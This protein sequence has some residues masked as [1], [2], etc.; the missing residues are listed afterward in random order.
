MKKKA[1]TP[2]SIAID[3][4]EANVLSR[5]GSNV[6]AY[7]VLTAVE[8]IIR[9]QTELKVTVLLA[10]PAVSDMP[11]ASKNWQYRVLG[12]KFLW[13]Q[14]ALPLHLFIHKNKYHVFFTPGH[15]APRICLIPYVSSVMDLAFLQYPE[16]FLPKDVY[17]LR[18]WTSY[19]VLGA[20]KIIAISNHT[21]SQVIKTYDKK[22][23]D[24]VVAY[25]A[26][27]KPAS[28]ITEKSRLEVLSKFNI[29]QP[30][31]LFVGTIQPRK[32]II[33]LVDAF[34]SLTKQE[35]A[36]SKQSKKVDT[37]LAKET[38]LV[39]AGR[40]GWLCESI[41]E[42]I[43]S[44]PV[45]N[46]IILTGFIEEKEKQALYESCICSVLI[47]LYEGFGIP[48][49]EALQ[50]GSIPVVSQTT[51]LPEVVG[52]AGIYVDPLKPK[53]ILIGL[54]EATGL[55]AKERATLHKKA[56]E[57][58]KKFSWDKTAEIILETLQKVA[59]N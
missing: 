10:R 8:K 18:A 49:L 33:R 16:Q 12:P 17:Q 43:E 59:E 57:Q 5:V 21:R 15:Y 13:T 20:K 23:S 42:R 53:S 6:Y 3:G 2:F 22:I 32:N 44:S 36:T 26:I 24:V 37:S 40:K 27:S 29:R 39:L 25:P 34:E 51:S 38:Q 41:I 55:K 45:R 35:V 11:S 19:S 50:Y 31:I 48:A 1:P 4:N 54:R 47:G 52:Q 56:R 46:K 7:E 30:F 28:K 9:N 58:L 14:W